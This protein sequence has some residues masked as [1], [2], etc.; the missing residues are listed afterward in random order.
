MSQAKSFRLSEEGLANQ[1]LLLHPFLSFCHSLFRYSE[2]EAGGPGPFPLHPRVR[3][4][5][6]SQSHKMPK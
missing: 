6:T 1:L 2:Y 4:L 5:V 3:I